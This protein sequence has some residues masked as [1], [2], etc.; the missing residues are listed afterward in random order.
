[1]THDEIELD[2]NQRIEDRLN[3]RGANRSLEGHIPRAGHLKVIHI[4]R[5]VSFGMLQIIKKTVW[6]PFG[7]HCWKFVFVLK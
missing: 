1:M 7:S 6:K 3:K 5:S 2:A 4:F